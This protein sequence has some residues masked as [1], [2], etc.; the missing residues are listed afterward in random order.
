M[1]PQPSLFRGEIVVF[2]RQMAALLRHFNERNL[3]ANLLSAPEQT[4]PESLQHGSTPGLGTLIKR[5][6][7]P[8]VHKNCEFCRDGNLSGSNCVE[9]S[10]D[11]RSF[12]DT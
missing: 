4:A 1:S 7:R 11:F 2:L 3:P 9:L 12:S 8:R 10:G 6:F 5:P